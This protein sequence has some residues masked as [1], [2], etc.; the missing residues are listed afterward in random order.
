MADPGIGSTA[1][2]PAVLSQATADAVGSAFDVSVDQ[3]GGRYARQQHLA[4]IAEELVAAVTAAGRHF[5]HVCLFA[6]RM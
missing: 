3:D 5:A 2:F 6:T 1:D 4:A